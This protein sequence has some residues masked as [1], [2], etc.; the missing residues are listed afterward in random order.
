MDHTT[1]TSE[2]VEFVLGA[3]GLVGLSPLLIWREQLI[4]DVIQCRPLVA[5]VLSDHNMNL[6]RHVAL[7]SVV[8]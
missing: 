1:P 6:T 2:K 4:S 3:E 8:L 5:I 7:K